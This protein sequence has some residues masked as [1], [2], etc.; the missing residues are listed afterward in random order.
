MK[1][2]LIRHAQA[3]HNITND[4]NI[5]DPSITGVG[6]QQC[7]NNRHLYKDADVV[8]TSTSTR[9][10]QT[11][12]ILFDHD[13]IYATDLLLE[14]Q[15]GVPCNQR[16]NIDT[17]KTNYPSIDFD[18]YYTGGINVETTWHDGEKR[19]EELINLIKTI[20]VPVLALVSHGNF[21]KN[22]ELLLTGK[23]SEELKNCEAHTFYI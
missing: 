20:K 5:F 4:I 17:L 14:Y 6:L 21:I 9:A 8:I 18:T 16:H 15:T 12:K 2:Y 7:N 13:V 22:V 10:I 3:K 19:A 11:T 23:I 1:I